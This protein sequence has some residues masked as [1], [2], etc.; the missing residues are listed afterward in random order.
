MNKKILGLGLGI[1]LGA[2]SLGQT[3]ASENTDIL[4]DTAYNQ[5]G[6][7]YVWGSDIMDSSSH[8]CSSLVAYC[9]R[10]LGISLPRCSYEQAYE[11]EEVAYDDIQAGDIICMRTSDRNDWV[12]GVTHV[13]IAINDHEMIHAKGRNYGVVRQEIGDYSGRIVTIR[14]IINN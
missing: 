14:R 7:P 12:N 11:G 13:G 10:Q 6:K 8:D 9:Y 4:V 1:L 3:F 5:L 2:L